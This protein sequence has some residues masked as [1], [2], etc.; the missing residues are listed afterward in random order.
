[1]VSS[2]FH[3]STS[4]SGPVPLVILAFDVSKTRK[5]PALEQKQRSAAKSLHRCNRRSGPFERI[6]A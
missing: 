6:G 3:S 1:M 4:S 2:K 5:T